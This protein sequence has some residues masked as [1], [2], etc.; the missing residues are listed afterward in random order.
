M[1]TDFVKF[2]VHFQLSSDISH[3]TL[4]HTTLQT[5]KEPCLC[6]KCQNVHLLLQGIN[7]YCSTQNLRK[8]YSVTEFLIVNLPLTQIIFLNAEIQKKPATTFLK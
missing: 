5:E 7:R 8:H 1:H 3:F 2:S 6:I 4:H